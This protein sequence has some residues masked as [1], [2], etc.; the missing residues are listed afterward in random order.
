MSDEVMEREKQFKEMVRNT[1]ETVA[2]GYGLGG[3]RF[4]HSA[5]EHM[6]ELLD[7]AG[8]EHVLDVASGTGATAIPLAHRLNGGKVTAVDFSPAMLEQSRARA[9]QK[10]LDNIDYKVHDMTAMPFAK[11]QFD[12]ATCS[13]GIFFVEDMVSLLNHIA[14]KVKPGGSVLVSGFCGESFMPVTNLLLDQL[15]NYGV[16]VPEK[17]F[18]WKRMAEQEQLHQLFDDA[19]LYNVDIQRRSLGYYVESEGWWEVVWNA[20]FRGLVNQVGDRLDE[21]KVE[22]FAEIESLKDDKGLWLEVDVYFTKGT[23]Q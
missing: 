15:R 8:N 18:G 11:G 16:D 5:G 21:F 12:N 23:T 14:S 3:A 10:G 1:F 13:F 9:E 17:P 7:L 22:H 4:F 2:N 6:A 20:G 19:G